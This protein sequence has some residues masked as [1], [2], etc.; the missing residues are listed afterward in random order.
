M[1]PNYGNYSYLSDTQALNFITGMGTGMAIFLIALAVFEI[2]CMWKLFEK[3][4]EPGWKCLIPIYNA[5]I[6]MKICWEGKYFWI[7]LLLLLSVSGCRTADDGGV[8]AELPRTHA[9]REGGAR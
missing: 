6:F 1:Y 9:D 3:A 8:M 4:G 7:M 2:V 5:Y